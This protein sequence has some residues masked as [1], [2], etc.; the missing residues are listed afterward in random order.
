MG[1][2]IEG[3]FP[4]QDGSR[5]PKVNPQEASVTSLGNH[6]AEVRRQKIARGKDRNPKGSLVTEDGTIVQ[7]DLILGLG[8]ILHSIRRLRRNPLIAD[9]DMELLGL[10]HDR[11]EL[12]VFM[13][14]PE[15]EWAD[16]VAEYYP[17]EAEDPGTNPPAA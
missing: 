16:M 12:E 17:F 7:D 4:N 5:T 6:T 2:L 10:Q 15:K 14:E 11:E 1:K 8:R 13:D 3:L 9:D